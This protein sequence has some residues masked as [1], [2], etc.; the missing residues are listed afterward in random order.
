MSCDL[1]VTRRSQQNASPN[2][3]LFTSIIWFQSSNSN[4]N[5][6]VKTIS[7]WRS[8]QSVC[9][10]HFALCFMSVLH[11]K[12]TQNDSANFENIFKL[13]GGCSLF[14]HNFS[15]YYTYFR[16]LEFDGK[17]RWILNSSDSAV[18][19]ELPAIEKRRF[20]SLRQNEKRFI[21][22]FRHSVH[23]SRVCFKK[24]RNKQTIHAPDRPTCGIVP[25]TVVNCEHTSTRHH[26]FCS[27][28]HSPLDSHCF[29]VRLD[30]GRCDCTSV[31]FQFLLKRQWIER[32]IGAKGL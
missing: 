5:K 20:Q 14:I 32:T 26:P 18:A 30:C 22:R 19:D 25:S 12:R 31:S 21:Y 24:P 4:S 17:N 9:S 23:F 27:A 16:W 8:A 29:R 6:A 10:I 1:H 15:S 11:I 28:S 3:D 2:I 13:E 7:R